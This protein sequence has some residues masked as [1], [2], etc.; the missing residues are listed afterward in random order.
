M[1]AWWPFDELAGPDA[2]DIAGSFASNGK[3]VDSPAIVQGR[4]GNALRFD[5]IT[6]RVEVPDGFDVDLGTGDLTIDAWVKTTEGGNVPIVDKRS[7]ERTGYA[8]YILD[9]QLALELG[10]RANHIPV[11]P[12]PCATNNFLTACTEYVAPAGSKLVN[13]GRWHHVAA[14]VDRDQTTG[15]TLYVDGAAVLTFDPTNRPLSLDNS[16]TFTIARR[17]SSGDPFRGDID[18]VEL[19]GRA[20]SAAEVQSIFNAGVSG[21]CKATCGNPSLIQSDYFTKGN[22]EVVVPYPGGGIAHYWRNNDKP[23]YPWTRQAVFGAAEGEV[24]AVSM[25]QSNFTRNFEVVARIGDR[26]A[27][28]TRTNGGG[29]QNWIGPDYFAAGVAGTPSLIQS[30]YGIKGDFQVVVPLVTGGLGLFTR[31]N[32]Q[33]GTPWS[34]PEI[35]AT[36]LGAIDDAALIQGDF[37]GHLEVVARIGDKLAHLWRDQFQSPPVWSA[38]TYFATGVAGAPSFL[39]HRGPPHPFFDVYAPLE[40]GSVGRWLRI[41]GPLG[42]YVWQPEGPIGFTGPVRAVSAIQSNFD[43]NLELLTQTCTDILHYWSSAP[44]LWNGTGSINP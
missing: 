36:N 22:F 21:K 14:T 40:D 30:N 37:S 35:F 25:I 26:L 6:Q 12:P 8:L 39:Q 18:E 29:P 33:T 19:F 3:Q 5:G 13:D 16:D 7:E 20:L 32:D 23:G 41:H 44:F 1:R 11:A 43:D 2:H 4:V 24:A 42:L 28:F 38:P 9:G 34:G 10:D 27:Y 15:G 31:K 17:G